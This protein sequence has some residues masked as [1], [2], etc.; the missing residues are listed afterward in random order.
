MHP[1]SPP[2]RRPLVH[3]LLA[4]LIAALLPA[5]AGPER[6]AEDVADATESAAEAVA[7]AAGTAWTTVADVLGD[8]PDATAAA[9]VRPT[10]AGSAEGTVTF[11]ETDDGLRVDVSLRG[12]APG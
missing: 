1:L 11:A 2:G 8:D 7:D 4:L 10:S 3:A 9:L 12:L 6:A 5:C